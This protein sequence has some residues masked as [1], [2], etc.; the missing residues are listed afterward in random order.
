MGHTLIHFENPTNA[1]EKL[2][3]F[4]E[5]VIGWKIIQADGPIEYWEI[6]IVPVAPDGMLTKSGVNGGI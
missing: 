5:N 3:R 6:Q 4:Y 2:K 1:V